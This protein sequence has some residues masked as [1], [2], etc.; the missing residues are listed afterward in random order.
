MKFMRTEMLFLIW[1]VPL[2]A[3]AFWYGL[4]KRR[5][6]LGKFA[7]A[8]SLPA[9]VPALMPGRQSFLGMSKCD[10]SLTGVTSGLNSSPLASAEVGKSASNA[11]QARSIV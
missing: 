2:L 1:A 10:S 8:R 5:R 9:L 6:V 4:R 3:L 7:H 11:F